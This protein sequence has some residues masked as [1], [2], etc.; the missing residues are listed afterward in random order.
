MPS[1]PKPK[2]RR[3]K[4]RFGHRRDKAYTAWIREQPCIIAGHERGPRVIWPRQH[5]C[6]PPI[7][8]CHVKSRGAGGSDLGNVVP[9][10]MIAHT[11]QH[12]WGIRTFSAEWGIDLKA[13]AEALYQTYLA[14]REP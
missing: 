2:P 10:C 9:M 13:T 1:V 14:T 4:K 11:Q 5:V 3:Q 7:Q 6:I 8:A 12:L